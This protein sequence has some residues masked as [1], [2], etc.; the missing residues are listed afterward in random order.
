MSY[1]GCKRTGKSSLIKDKGLKRIL[2]GS[3]YMQLQIEEI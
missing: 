3:I 1:C 2:E